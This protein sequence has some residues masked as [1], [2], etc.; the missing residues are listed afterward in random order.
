M[1]I[2]INSNLFQFD[3]EAGILELTNVRVSDGHTLSADESNQLKM[4]PDNA[5]AH[6]LLEW[7]SQQNNIEGNSQGVKYPHSINNNC[8]GNVKYTDI[9]Y[10][11]IY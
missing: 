1:Q 10:Y 3:S 2:F 4:N 9:K 8:E 7:L 11:Y 6:R 5:Q